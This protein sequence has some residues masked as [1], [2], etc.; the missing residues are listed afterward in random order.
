MRAREVLAKLEELEREHYVSPIR[1]A[2]VHSGSGNADEA[3]TFLET[4]YERHEDDLLEQ[5]T[6]AVWD[7]IR[8]DSRFQNL[9]RR[10][11]LHRALRTSIERSLTVLHNDRLNSTATSRVSDRLAI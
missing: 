9:V 4:A 5:N 10:L 2:A 7:P 11:G 8:H 3:M 6:N 1:F